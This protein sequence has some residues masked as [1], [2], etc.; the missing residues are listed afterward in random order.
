MTDLEHADISRRLALAIG[1]VEADMIGGRT[2][3]RIMD[4]AG[5]VLYFDYRDP[6][7]IWPIAERF[8]AFPWRVYSKNRWHANVDGS[9]PVQMADTAALAV[10]LAVIKAKEQP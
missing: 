2:Q 7:V 4:D 1:W 3:I 9:G 10:A 5:W 6:E 8:N